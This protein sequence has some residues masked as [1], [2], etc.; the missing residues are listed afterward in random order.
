MPGLHGIGNRLTL[1]HPQLFHSHMK[2][3][4][5]IKI[6]RKGIKTRKSDLNN[7]F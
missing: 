4:D 3:L 1:Q 6:A 2:K 7:N 5:V